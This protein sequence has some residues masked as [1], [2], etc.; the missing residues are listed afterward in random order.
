[1][2]TAK[3]SYGYD[4][5]AYEQAEINDPFVMRFTESVEEYLQPV[6][7]KLCEANKNTVTQ[8]IAKY[9]FIILFSLDFGI[10]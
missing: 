7:P 5:T 10:L 3:I 9:I 1:M 6:L 4:E 8:N 2:V